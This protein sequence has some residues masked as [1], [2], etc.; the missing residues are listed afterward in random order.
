MPKYN[1]HGK[2]WES[3]LTLKMWITPE[4][5]NITWTPKSEHSEII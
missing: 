3:V 1:L 4:G 2:E 5:F